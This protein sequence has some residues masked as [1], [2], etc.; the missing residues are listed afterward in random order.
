MRPRPRHAR[1]LGD[2]SWPGEGPEPGQ[3]RARQQEGL[4]ML[5]SDSR[6]GGRAGARGRTGRAAWSAGRLA[7]WLAGWPTG[8]LFVM[9]PLR[10]SVSE[11][12]NAR[13]RNVQRH[14]ISQDEEVGVE[15]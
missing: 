1:R 15:A 5:G 8:R 2:N 4:W 3:L 7:G 9:C 14:Y 11:R 10:R 12:G 13:Y 6:V